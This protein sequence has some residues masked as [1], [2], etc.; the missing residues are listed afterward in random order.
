MKE[1]F[2]DSNRYKLL[3]KR[4]YKAAQDLDENLVKK[5]VQDGAPVNYVDPHS[6]QTSIFPL[7]VYQRWDTVDFLLDTGECDLLIRNKNNR[8]LSTRVAEETGN[9]MWADK[10]MDIELEQ[11]R[12]KG[13]IPRIRGNDKIEPSSD[14]T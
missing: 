3:G 9:R 11:G 6:G 13:I 12:K 14:P 2:A 1:E 10:I 5:L 7:A 4:L 8:L